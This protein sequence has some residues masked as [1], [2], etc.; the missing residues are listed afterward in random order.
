MW[1]VTRP[2]CDVWSVTRPTCDV[3][4]VAR[5]TCDVWS[6][7]R[8]TCG[9]WS[10]TR[11]TSDVWSVTRPTCD[12]WSVARPTCDV[13]SVARPTCDMWSVA[14]PTCGVWFVAGLRTTWGGRTRTLSTSSSRRLTPP[15][16][17]SWRDPHSSPWSVHCPQHTASSQPLPDCPSL[18]TGPRAG[19]EVDAYSVGPG[20]LAESVQPLMYSQ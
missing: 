7:T 3:W 5:P 12:M 18:T 10:V 11:P 14:R 19:R 6:V 8:P 4:S 9:V 20:V 17:T 15:G 16:C 13:W 2:T 1:S